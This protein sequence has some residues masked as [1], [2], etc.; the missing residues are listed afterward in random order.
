M[1]QYAVKDVIAVGAVAEIIAAL[2]DST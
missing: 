1:F 2:P